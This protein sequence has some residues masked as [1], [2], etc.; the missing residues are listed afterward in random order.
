MVIN[1]EVGIGLVA[2]F[3]VR[4]DPS[5]SLRGAANRLLRR[6]PQTYSACRARTSPPVYR[7]DD[8]AA[9][10]LAWHSERTLDEDLME[11]KR[12]QT[13]DRQ[14]GGSTWP[15]FLHHERKTHVGARAQAVD[16]RSAG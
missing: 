4:R 15:T 9:L 10:V 6:P 2:R 5:T 1:P 3:R 12:G 8:S 13:I 14:H 11:W 16:V 7:I